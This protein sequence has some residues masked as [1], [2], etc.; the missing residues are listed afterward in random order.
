MMFSD[1][2][3]AFLDW[4]TRLNTFMPHR[5]HSASTLDV[6]IQGE[7][8]VLRLGRTIPNRMQAQKLN[9]SCH[10]LQAMASKFGWERKNTVFSPRSDR[11]KDAPLL[12]AGT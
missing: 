7:I 4:L 3:R 10:R 12:I 8:I 11:I 5:I 6:S 9:V 1:D 2:D